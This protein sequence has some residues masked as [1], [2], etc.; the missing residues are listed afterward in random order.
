MRIRVRNDSEPIHTWF[1]LTYASYLV[2][3]RSVLQSAS[4]S[5][6]R[7]LVAV[8]DDLH[9]EF[10]SVPDEGVHY[11]VQTKDDRGR[12]VADRFRDYERGRRKIVRVTPAKEQAK[13]EER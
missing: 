10:G 9:E 6:Q 7:R 3:P 5:I 2:L 8:L 4:L 12:F 1:G 13:R 11:T